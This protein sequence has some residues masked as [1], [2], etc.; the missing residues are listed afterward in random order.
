[1]WETLYC[2]ALTGKCTRCVKEC[3]CLSLATPLP[4]P[5]FQSRHERGLFIGSSLK[6]ENLNAC[7]ICTPELRNAAVLR[8]LPSSCPLFCLPPSCSSSFTCSLCDN[9]FPSQRSCACQPQSFRCFPIACDDFL[10]S[11]LARLQN[12]ALE[13]LSCSSCFLLSPHFVSLLSV[14]WTSDFLKHVF[15]KRFFLV[16]TSNGLLL[17][18]FNSAFMF[19]DPACYVTFERS[20]WVY[21]WGNWSDGE[22]LAFISWCKK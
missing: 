20:C 22:A 14:L 4:N 5:T 11:C 15:F 16:K 17:Q 8:F 13:T 19:S 9:V 10:V 6:E 2:S 3:L 18:I 1:M 7:H 21:R 12:M